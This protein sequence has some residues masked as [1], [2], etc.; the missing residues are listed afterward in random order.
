MNPV[1]YESRDPALGSM[2]GR[3]A[4]HFEPMPDTQ[5]THNA[6]LQIPNYPI[7][8]VAYSHT[9]HRRSHL[10]LDATGP[11]CIRHGT[12]LVYGHCFCSFKRRSTGIN[13]DG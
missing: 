5:W 3:S 9:V 10:Q 11:P 6:G 2:S 7:D 12:G 8:V 13:G 1:P 4:L